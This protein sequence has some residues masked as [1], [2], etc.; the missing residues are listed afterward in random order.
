[1]AAIYGP[2]IINGASPHLADLARLQPKVALFLDPNP[3]DVAQFRAVCPN[4]IC[5]GRIYVPDSEVE[6]RIAS[7][8]EI[9]ATWAHILITKHPARKQIHYWQ[10]ANEV[11]QF[12][13]KLPLINR[14]FVRWMQLADAS[15]YKCAVLG[16]SVGQLDMPANDRLA[17]WRMVYPTCAYAEAHGHIALVHQYGAPDLWGPP[18][19]GG[20]PWL[21]NRLETQVLPLLPYPNLKF[22][23]GEYGIDGLLLMDLGRSLAAEVEDPGVGVHTPSKPMAGPDM[24]TA[25]LTRGITGPTGWQAFTDAPGYVKQLTDMGQWL[26]QFSERILGY[27]IF[28]LGNNSPW[29][30]YDIQGAVLRGLAD[31]YSQDQPPVVPPVVPPEVS[32]TDPR[33]ANCK[34]FHLNAEGKVDGIELV[35]TPVP[36]ARYACVS[37]QLID[38]AAAQGN[39]VVTVDIFDANGIRTAERALMEWPYGGPPAAESPVGSGNPSNQFATTSKYAP[40]AIGPL[41]FM[42]GDANKQPI[43]DHIWGYGLPGGRHIS[44]Y[45]A[46]K[47]R[48]M[49]EPPSNHQ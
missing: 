27:C 11:C 48:T 33:S 16:W 3:D 28:T 29:Q 15:G 26:G 40:P 20:A 17:L 37:A 19:K 21:V 9:A 30:S 44:G 24:V 7:D 23:V 4:T 13:D 32:M 22:V 47:E 38:E 25:Y 6:G 10:I 5:I 35:Y 39:T 45:V 8:P 41:G 49:T 43:S 12:F 34:A 2:H 31:Y 1:M 42:V 14:F 18:E 46:F 36:S